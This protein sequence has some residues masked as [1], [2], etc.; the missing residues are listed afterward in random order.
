L[1]TCFKF[2]RAIVSGFSKPKSWIFSR[3]VWPVGSANGPSQGLS[4]GG[5]YLMRAKETE[6]G[7]NQNQAE[8]RKLLRL[9]ILAGLM[10]P[11]ARLAVP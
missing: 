2:S 6:T 8:M 4:R 7:W 10:V 11:A 1:L 3:A 9:T 5:F